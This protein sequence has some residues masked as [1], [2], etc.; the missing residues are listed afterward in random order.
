MRLVIHWRR[1]KVDCSILNKKSDLSHRSDELCLTPLTP[2]LCLLRGQHVCSYREISLGYIQ[3][4]VVIV[5]VAPLSAHAHIRNPFHF[6]S[7]ACSSSKSSRA[8]L[9]SS[10]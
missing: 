8:A 6:L 10:S 1:S 3:E 4:A 9:S 2:L 7:H 5:L